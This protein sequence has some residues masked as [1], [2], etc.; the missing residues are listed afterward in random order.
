MLSGRSP[1]SSFFPISREVV[2]S[3]TLTVLHQK[4]GQALGKVNREV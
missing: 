2:L 1:R 3:S 4:A